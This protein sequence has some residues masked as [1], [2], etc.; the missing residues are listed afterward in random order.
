[1]PEAKALPWLWLSAVLVVL[2]QY[3][4][5]LAVAALGSGQ[6]IAVFPGLNWALAYNYGAAFSFLNIPGGGQRWFFSVLAI[7]ISGVLITWLARTARSDWRSALPLALIISGAIGNLI[8]RVR[9]GY[10][11]DFVDVYYST[12]HWP[13]FNVADSAISVGAVMLIL[14][15]VII[16]PKSGESSSG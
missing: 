12:H 4:K 6:E 13:A 9:L 16:Q 11:V 5:W 2:D 14:F 8:D 7:V 3:T 1:M 15:G 10:V